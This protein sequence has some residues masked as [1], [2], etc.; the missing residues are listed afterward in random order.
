AVT[1]WAWATPA[2]GPSPGRPFAGIFMAVLRPRFATGLAFTA[3]SPLLFSV[4][5]GGAFNAP[6]VP[7]TALLSRS[8]ENVG[9]AGAL[10]FGA[11]NF[12]WASGYAVGA[13]LGGV[14]AD[15]GGDALPYLSL[16]AVCLLALLVLRRVI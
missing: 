3:F 7:G 8:A 13:S 5:A 10:A 12:A 14:L 1:L 2:P 15:F 16:A 9:I 11:A 6:L 4:L